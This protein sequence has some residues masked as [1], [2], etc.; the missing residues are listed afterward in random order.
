MPDRLEDGLNGCIMAAYS[1]K[2]A[3]SHTLIHW[4]EIRVTTLVRAMEGVKIDWLEIAQNY[5]FFQI[6]IF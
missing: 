3:L 6:L 5:I 2:S 4:N 1:S